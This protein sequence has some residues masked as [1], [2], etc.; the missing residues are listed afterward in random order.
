MF[1][2]WV[3]LTSK[4]QVQL[5]Q[6]YLGLIFNVKVNALTRHCWLDCFKEQRFYISVEFKDV[7]FY[8]T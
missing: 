5:F 8:K 2:Y 1:C 7:D 3:L 6:R 4:K